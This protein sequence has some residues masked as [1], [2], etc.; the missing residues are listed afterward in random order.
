MALGALPVRVRRGGRRRPDFRARPSFKE[1]RGG[2]VSIASCGTED[3]P[4][5]PIMNEVWLPFFYYRI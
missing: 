4:E 1:D 3:V 2:L 5:I